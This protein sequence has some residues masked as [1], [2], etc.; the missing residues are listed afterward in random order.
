MQCWA[1]RFFGDDV[2]TRFL[3]AFVL[4]ATPAFAQVP[5]PF[6]QTSPTEPPIE[7]KV[8][9]PAGP[10]GPQGP[11]GAPGEPGPQGPAGPEGPPGVGEPG[12]MGPAGPQGPEGLAGPQG[13]P[14]RDACP[15]C[16]VET[17]T[18]ESIHWDGRLP[19]A[20]PVDAQFETLWRIGK[21]NDLAVFSPTAQAMGFFDFNP[22]DTTI[23]GRYIVFDRTSPEARW[24]WM[25]A[26]RPGV[27]HFIAVDGTWCIVDI[28]R[29]IRIARARGRLYL[30]W[31][32]FREAGSQDA[33]LD[34][35]QAA[36]KIPQDI[37]DEATVAKGRR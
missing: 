32:V 18:T 8:E 30:D 29:L 34:M 11:P 21:R 33:L 20:F 25:R 12:P 10:S 16:G 5:N 28:E 1:A 9:C 4:L 19:F 26:L 17:Q 7:C 6:Q 22:S 3:L 14:G 37:W 31:Q 15:G 35:P 13:P 2:K 36:V 23:T 27:F 24:Q